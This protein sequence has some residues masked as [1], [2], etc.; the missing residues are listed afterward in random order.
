MCSSLLLSETIT[1]KEVII[2]IQPPYLKI[3]DDIFRNPI[4]S[5]ES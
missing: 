5:E 2:E 4:V 1:V 3:E